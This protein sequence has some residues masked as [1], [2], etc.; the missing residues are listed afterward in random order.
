MQLVLTVQKDAFAFQKPVN[1]ITAKC[2]DY[3]DIIKRPMDLGTIQKKFPG[4]KPAER[5]AELREYKSP[6]EFRDDVRLVWSNC[7]DY[8]AVGHPVRTM[9]DALS[10]QWEKRWT[11]SGIE[12]KWEDELRKQELEESVSA[13]FYSAYE[14]YIS[15]TCKEKMELATERFTAVW[16]ELGHAGPHVICYTY[17]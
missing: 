10:E 1:P 5:K 2:P 3:Y 15:D 14:F 9:G 17:V 16:C 13:S 11:L 6:L 7:R 8:N 12:A 4:R